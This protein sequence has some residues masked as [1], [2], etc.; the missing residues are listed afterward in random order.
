MVG[1]ART[2]LMAYIIHTADRTVRYFDQA[3]KTLAND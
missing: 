2:Q 1:Y 3:T